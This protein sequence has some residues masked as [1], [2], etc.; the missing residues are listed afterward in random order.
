L[1]IGFLFEIWVLDIGISTDNAGLRRW[2]S[3]WVDTFHISITNP[4]GQ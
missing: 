2:M 4:T 3:F 1:V